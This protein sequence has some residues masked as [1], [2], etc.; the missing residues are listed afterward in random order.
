MKPE[1]HMYT[2]TRGRQLNS[3]CFNLLMYLFSISESELLVGT[4]VITLCAVSLV[5]MR[6][7][8]VVGGA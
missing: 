1:R 8:S 7:F 5:S 4:H 3:T 2:D 6:C